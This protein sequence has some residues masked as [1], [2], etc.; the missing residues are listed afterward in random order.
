[1]SGWAV[2]W[3]RTSGQTIGPVGSTRWAVHHVARQLAAAG[4]VATVLREVGGGWRE[5]ARYSDD[6]TRPDGMSRHFPWIP[7]SARRRPARVPQRP[8]TGAARG[9]AGPARSAPPRRPEDGRR[10]RRRP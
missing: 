5:V 1:M 2:T 3:T 7:T 4:G 8:P 6:G 10:F 9:S